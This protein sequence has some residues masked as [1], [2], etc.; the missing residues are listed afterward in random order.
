MDVRLERVRSRIGEPAPNGVA[1]RHGIWLYGKRHGDFVILRQNLS[2][3]RFLASNNQRGVVFPKC[4]LVGSALFRRDFPAPQIFVPLEQVADACVLKVF[5]PVDGAGIKS[6]FLK[7]FFELIFFEIGHAFFQL[8][9]NVL[10]RVFVVDAYP[11]HPILLPQKGF[12]NGIRQG[13]FPVLKGFID[14]FL[15]LF[16]FSTFFQLLDTF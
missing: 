1:I 7:P 14:H 3:G 5:F 8:I 15:G 10:L 11:V 2:V 16:E 9:Q 4:L 12:S 13:A 6:S